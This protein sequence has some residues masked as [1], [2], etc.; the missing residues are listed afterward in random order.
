MGEGKA[1]KMLGLALLRLAVSIT[2]DDVKELK[3]GG[4]ADEAKALI[5]VL[6]RVSVKWQGMGPVDPRV[7]VSVQV[8]LNQLRAALGVKR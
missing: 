7:F 8:R 5:E 1:K 6:H 3:A 2:P 4:C